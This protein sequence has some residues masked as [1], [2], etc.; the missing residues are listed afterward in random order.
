MKP[1]SESS[2][3]AAQPLVGARST[4]IDSVKGFA[5]VLVVY[6]HTAQGICHRNWW[7]GPAS[8][9]SDSFVYSFHMPVFFFVAGL[10]LAGSLARRGAAKFVVE[11]CRTILYPYVLWGVVGILLEPMIGQFKMSTTAFDGKKFLLDL[12]S[13]ELSW[14]LPVLFACQILALGIWKVPSWWRLAIALVAA[15]LVPV[16]GP[17]ILYKSVQEFCFLAAG[18]VVGQSI[19]RLS[20]LP[21]WAAVV[22]SM[23]LFCFQFAVVF[24]DGEQAQFGGRD[25]WLAIVLGLTGTAGLLL[26]ARAIDGTRLGDAWAWVGKASL[27]IFL[28]SAY[29]QGATREL[30]LRLLHTHAILPQLIVPTVFATVL[31]AI[32]WHQKERWHLEWLFRWPGR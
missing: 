1:P 2:P 31:P 12:A 28:L 27:G 24:S 16:Y 15:A 7:S 22:G 20:N 11:K 10:F 9:L 23:L 3:V 25:Q 4:L 8:V 6:G 5:I 19:L 32:V 17:S 21:V 18:M 30:L 29:P 26:L 14:F 13:G